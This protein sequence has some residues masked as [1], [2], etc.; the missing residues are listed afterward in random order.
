M[1]PVRQEVSGEL[2]DREFGGGYA[3][4]WRG[5]RWTMMRRHRVWRPPTDVYETDSHVVIRVEVAGVREDD[6][7]VSLM[8]RR[9]VISGWRRDPAAKLAYQR[10]EINYGEFRTVLDLSWSPLEDEIEAHYED[11]FLSVFLPKSR[12]T[13]VPVIVVEDDEV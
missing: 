2:E 6:F 10:M 13:H 5:E 4:V 3:S 9:L 7:Q 11:G 8:E 1:R 12:E